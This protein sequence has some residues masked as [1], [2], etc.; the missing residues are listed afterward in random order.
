MR[1]PHP[2]LVSK[3][4]SKVGEAKA[5]YA[6]KK[7]AKAVVHSSVA[8]KD[9][10]VRYIDPETARKLTKDILDKHHDLFRK[11]AQ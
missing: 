11:L 10:Q 3:K 7:P 8:S 4:P 2:A 9:G 6:A 1:Q 5:P